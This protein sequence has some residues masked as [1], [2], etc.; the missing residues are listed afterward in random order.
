VAEKKGDEGQ[1]PFAFRRIMSHSREYRFGVVSLT[2]DGENS[3]AL[4]V[5]SHHSLCGA[6]G[7][8]LEV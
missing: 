4:F 3:T 6:S 2:N 1:N 8:I 5:L 7:P